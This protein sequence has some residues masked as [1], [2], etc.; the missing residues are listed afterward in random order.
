[1]ILS[2]PA[3][4]WRFWWFCKLLALPYCNFSAALRARVCGRP[5]LYIFTMGSTSPMPPFEKPPLEHRTLLA[6]RRLNGHDVRNYEFQGAAVC[7]LNVDLT[8]GQD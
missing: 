1:M 6:G 4:K 3:K 2:G 7:K 5:V 8:S